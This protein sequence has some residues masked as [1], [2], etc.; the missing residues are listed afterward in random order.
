[1]RPNNAAYDFVSC[2]RALYVATSNRGLIRVSPLPPDWDY[3]LLET[4][5][6]AEGRI[7]MLRVH[8]LGTAYGPPEDRIDAE[9]VI[10]L[11]TEPDKAFG[12]QLRD[13]AN[14]PAAEG[15]LKLLRDA[16]NHGRRVRIDF[17]R[18]SCRTGRIIRVIER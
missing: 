8:D 13:D 16:F 10:W 3:P 18:S 14:R 11:D 6:G 5:Q 2:P 15:M 1:M 12:F 9:V 7:T 17:S 4:L